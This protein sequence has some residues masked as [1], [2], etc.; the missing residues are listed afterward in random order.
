[1][2]G[3]PVKT[4]L[5]VLSLSEQIKSSERHFFLEMTSMYAASFLQMKQEPYVQ[6]CLLTLHEDHQI[7]RSKKKMAFEILW[8]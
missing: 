7:S 8:K 1:M 4:N 3:F 2:C 5:P 6:F